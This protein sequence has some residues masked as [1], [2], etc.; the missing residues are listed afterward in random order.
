MPLKFKRNSL[1]S[2]FTPGGSEFKAL[3][4]DENTLRA[5]PRSALKAAECGTLE[6]KI[7]RMESLFIILRNSVRSAIVAFA[8]LGPFDT[9]SCH[10]NIESE[11]PSIGTA[12]RYPSKPS[13]LC[14]ATRDID[15]LILSISHS[16]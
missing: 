12:I 4:T 16:T 2:A 7:F 5:Y 11:G 10:I 9:A 13:L 6:K 3:G 14:S 1:S 8:R 15:P